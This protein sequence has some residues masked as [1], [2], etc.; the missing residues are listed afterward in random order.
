MTWTGTTGETTDLDPTIQNLS[1][2]SLRPQQPTSQPC[3]VLDSSEK[4]QL[5][6]NEGKT[7]RE[8]TAQAGAVFELPGVG[9][10]AAF[11]D[12][13]NDGDIDVV[14]TDAN[15]PVR[16]LLNQ[17]GS[18]NHWL[19]ARLQGV[20]AN[21]DGYGSIVIL[22]RKGRPPLRRRVGTDGSYLSAHDP[23]VHFGLGTDA[24][25]REAPPE[26][27][28]VIWPDG[29]KESWEATQTER[30]M[31]LTEGKGKSVR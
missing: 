18:R 24:E 28:V 4:N 11:G 21:R 23:R 5:F 3:P 25:L 22:H 27:L 2:Q 14:V 8:V 31:L 12:I 6:H 20:R 30:V 17:I 9:R 13:D 29:R 1:P 26:N 10:G 15:G 19:Q 16:L 7:F